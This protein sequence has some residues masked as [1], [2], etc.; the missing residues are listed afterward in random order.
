VDEAGPNIR[1]G[2]ARS[3]NLRVHGGALKLRPVIPIPLASVLVRC[4]APEGLRLA[5]Q[6][7]CAAEACWA[8]E[9]S[10][11][12]GR[13]ACHPQGLPGGW[14]LRRECTVR[15]NPTR[16]ET[17]DWRTPCV[18]WCSVAK[19]GGVVQKWIISV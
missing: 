15:G 9:V 2:S 16:K 1:I 8:T 13:L 6:F 18:P 11:R 19:A 3:R 7:G 17:T 4:L 12:L 10:L 14:C 5:P